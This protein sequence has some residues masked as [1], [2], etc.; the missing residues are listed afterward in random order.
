MEQ[1]MR[2]LGYMLLSILFSLAVLPLAGQEMKVKSFE[3]RTT[4]I[5]GKVKP[6]Y[7]NN[8]QACALIRVEVALSNVK[9]E[10]MVMGEPIEKTGEYFVYVPT[11]AS[12]LKIKAEGYL[13]LE[14]VF[15]EKLIGKHTYGMRILLPGVPDAGELPR[16]TAQYVVMQVEPK[17]AMVVID[18]MPRQLDENGMLFLELSLG[19]H[20]Y[21]VLASG[22]RTQQGTFPL[23]DTEK[24]QLNLK[25]APATGWLELSSVP[26]DGVQVL[27]DGNGVGTTPCRLQLSGGE[28][29]LQLLK[30]GYLSHTEKISVV[31]GQTLKLQRSLKINSSEVVL[32]AANPKAEIWVSG[33]KVGVGT[34]AGPLDAGTYSVTSRCAGYE[35]MI[36]PIEVRPD[37][38]R[39]F[40]LS[41]Q[42]PVY[43][44]LK[45]A[46]QPM[47][48]DIYLDG[49]KIGQQTP[50]AD[51]RVLI[52][53]H[54]LWV[55]K[56][57]YN[58][59][60]REVEIK[61]GEMT[62]L[63][64]KMT[65][66][67][68]RLPTQSP[69]TASP[70]TPATTTP[71]TTTAEASGE[72]YKVGD[73]YNRGNL[74]GIVFWVDASGRHGKILSMAE[75]KFTWDQPGM[76][77]LCGASNLKDGT[78][79][80]TKGE[81]LSAPSFLYC[82]SQGV[83]WYMPS[84][85]ELMQ[86]FR[87]KAKINATLKKMNQ[88]FLSQWYWS[89]TERDSDQAWCMEFYGGQSYPKMKD[90]AQPV[91]PIANF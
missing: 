33:Q 19:E 68:S 20:S 6:R 91:R 71:A 50:Y 47:G 88:K 90:V 21:Q 41:E 18:N 44:M 83:E 24:T 10:G 78:Q 70:A 3:H 22:Y 73:Y 53:R 4:D 86:I 15:P 9:F 2:N 63:V 42:V 74:R 55:V 85:E 26:A 58:T 69:A 35:D 62:N 87:A 37:G 13:P 32:K 54:T 39:T 12:S 43:G 5:T 29:M 48:A 76:N 79:N 16:P 89:S 61:R 52:G 17:N 31:D 38:E 67:E 64:V 36:D 75:E 66:G 65:A 45:V 56:Q 30:P 8:E 46:S 77:R 25:L 51:S 81:S 59:E 57:G 28:H 84:K 27:I 60:L 40:N 72:V 82:K 34:W 11:L 14:Y 49:R 23:I 7:D 80:Q 1:I